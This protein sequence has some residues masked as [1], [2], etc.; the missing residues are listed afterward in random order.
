MIVKTLKLKITSKYGPRWGR[1]HKGID[2]RSVSGW[3]DLD[4]LC[5]EKSEVLRVG[6]DG[7]GNYFL[8]V[9]PLENT[10]FK[11]LKF[12]HIDDHALSHFAPKMILQKDE[13]IGKAIIGG[14]SRSKHLHFE[15]W[16]EID[17]KLDHTNPEDYLRITQRDYDF[18]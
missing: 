2:L 11:E 16:I 14:N 8:V 13:Y 15:T 5:P 3:K 7:Y 9:K 6:R 17:E 4:I 12:I 18:K 1:F 10:Q